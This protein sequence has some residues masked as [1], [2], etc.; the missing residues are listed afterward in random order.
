M[1]GLTQPPSHP[2]SGAVHGASLEDSVV[3]G[4]LES[5]VPTDQLG[6]SLD[7]HARYEDSDVHGLTGSNSSG[8]RRPW[9]SRARYKGQ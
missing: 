4:S 3:L 1:T 2:I 9:Q 6:A 8:R 7:S 5:V